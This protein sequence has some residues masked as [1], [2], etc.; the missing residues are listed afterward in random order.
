M[1]YIEV[2]GCK[3]YHRPDSW[4]I[5]VIKAVASG[6][7]YEVT[8][9]EGDIVVDAGA[10]IGTFSIPCAK[11]GAKVIAY[12]PSKE[13]YEMLLKNAELN[14]VEIEAHNVALGTPGVCKL[15][16]NRKNMGSS[17]LSNT[18]EDVKVV[19]F[20]HKKVDILKLDCEGCEYEI[21]LPQAKVIV[22]EIHGSK[23]NAFV[24][25]LKSIGYTVKSQQSR[26]KEAIIIHAVL[27]R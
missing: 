22:G 21:D 18:G 7:E 5:N 16:T 19:P 10:H 3:F 11:A 14:G 4:D 23:R 27:N 6:R 13:N 1:E 8:P 12:E 25:R 26:A 17:H 9:K 2:N 20:T 15:K 24:A